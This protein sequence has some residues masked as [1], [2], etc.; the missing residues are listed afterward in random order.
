MSE[1][2]RVRVLGVKDGFTQEDVVAALATLFGRPS[3]EIQKIF[4]AKRVV[5]KNRMD[6]ME[7]RKFRLTLEQRTAQPGAGG[8]VAAV[9]PAAAGG[10]AGAGAACA[11]LLD[12]G[13]WAKLT[14]IGPK[15]K[16]ATTIANFKSIFT[17]LPPG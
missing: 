17:G 3:A 12:L 7:A 6:L 14:P 10:A 16:R 8:G 1:T 13:A 11:V 15:A 5:L 4:A 9:V 2:Y